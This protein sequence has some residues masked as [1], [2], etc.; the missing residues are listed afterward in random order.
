MINSLS[1]FDDWMLSW[2][3]WGW[4]GITL[5]FI[6]SVSMIIIGGLILVTSRGYNTGMAIK[7]IIPGLIIFVMFNLVCASLF[8]FDYQKF[9]AWYFQEFL[10]SGVS[11]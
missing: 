10:F 5:I 1:Y 7:L 11:L 4:F 6:V 9:L 3:K 8:G 2:A